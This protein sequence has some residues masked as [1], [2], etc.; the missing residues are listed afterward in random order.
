MVPNRDDNERDVWEAQAERIR[1]F[2]AWQ[3]G[4]E[5][6]AE[7]AARILGKDKFTFKFYETRV[8]GGLPAGFHGRFELLTVDDIKFLWACGI[9]PLS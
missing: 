3:Q 2:E 9:D 7:W 5:T 1:Q 6:G 4:A 8:L